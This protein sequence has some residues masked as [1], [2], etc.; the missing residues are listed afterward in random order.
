MTFRF[1]QNIAF[2]RPDCFDRKKQSDTN[3][4]TA[5]PFAYKRMIS[6]SLGDKPE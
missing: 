4:L 6:S 5:Q 1:R 2:V 3:I